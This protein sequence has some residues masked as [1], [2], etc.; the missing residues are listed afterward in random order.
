[1]ENPVNDFT[2]VNAEDGLSL[3][4]VGD[5]YRLVITGEQTGGAYAAIDMLVPPQGGPGPHAHAGFQESFYV[6]EGEVVIQTKSDTFTA[7]KGSFVN[8]PLG[9]VVHGFKNLSDTTARLL[10]MAVPAGLDEF[11]REVGTPVSAGTFLPPPVMSPEEQERLRSIA[12]KYGQEL[13]PPDYFD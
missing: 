1:M 7:R 5:T 4:V 9:G 3:S 8:I 13:F 10:C 2:A 12:E 6:L 11:F